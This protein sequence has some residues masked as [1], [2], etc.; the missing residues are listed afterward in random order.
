[1]QAAELAARA[2][3]AAQ[4]AAST[5][6]IGKSSEFYG[7]TW[8]A[9]KG[10]WI[11]NVWRGGTKHHIDYYA[12]EKDAALAVDDWLLEHG[13]D[14]VNFDAEGNRI[15]RQ[16][17]DSSIYR[18]V[19]PG[20]R[21]GSWKAQIRVDQKTENLGHYDTQ[22]EAAEAFDERAWELGKPTNFRF[23]GTRNNLGANGKVVPQRRTERWTPK[24]S[25]QSA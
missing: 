18:G 15:V 7:V 13:E 1:V 25:W 24:L 9:G 19:T 12:V 23:D 22:E 20:K 6:E 3:S 14:R 8:H 4:A 16:S 10:K 11:A 17:T 21:K 2:A 5:A